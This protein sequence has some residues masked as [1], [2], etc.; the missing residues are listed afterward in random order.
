[1]Q[2]DLPRSGTIAISATIYNADN[3]S[4]GQFAHLG[5][6]DHVIGGSILVWTLPLHNT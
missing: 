6:P 2:L 3:D 1:M 5:P 4:P